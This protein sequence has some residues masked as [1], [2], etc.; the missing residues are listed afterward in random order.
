M[1]STGPFQ[2]RWLKGY[3]YSSCCYHNQIGRI[4]LTHCY[5]VFRGCVPEMFLTSYNVTYCIYIPGKPEFFFADRDR[6]LYI[7][8]SYYYHCTNV[9]EDIE[10][11]K[12]LSDKFCRVC[13]IEIEHILSV[14]HYTIYGAVCLS[15]YASPLWWSR[16]YML[17]LII[18][19]I[20]SKVWTITHC[21]GIG[22]EIM[23]CAVCLFIFLYQTY[24]SSYIYC[25]L[26]GG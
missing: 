13:K 7:T 19:I 24:T 1:C 8:A 16:E 11:I 2:F 20:K 18:I 5:H 10:R 22:H 6:F 23:V 12:Y 3:I 15:V 25:H 21:L 4:N 14:I 17:C 26:Y 9:S